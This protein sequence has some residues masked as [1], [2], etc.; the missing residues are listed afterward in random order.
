MSAEDVEDIYII[1]FMITRF[2]LFGA[3]G[4]LVYRTFQKQSAPVGKL[5]D[6]YKGMCCAVNTPTQ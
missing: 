3:G 2:L 5:S 6:L 4:F 1:G